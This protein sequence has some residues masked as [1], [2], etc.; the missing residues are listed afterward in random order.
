MNDDIFSLC[1]NDELLNIE[2]HIRVRCKLLFGNSVT[3]NL[4]FSSLIKYYNYIQF[5]FPKMPYII[6]LC[7]LTCDVNKL[8]IK[9][10]IVYF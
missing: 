10:A 5:K 2:L 4:S 9:S 8:I 1:F 3:F 7:N 6:F